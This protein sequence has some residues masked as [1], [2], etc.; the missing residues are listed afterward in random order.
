MNMFPAMEYAALR[1]QPIQKLRDV[2]S[3]VE[4]LLSYSELL[5]AELHIKLDTFHADITTALE[6]RQDPDG[7]S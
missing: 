1:Q 4:E 3:T 2:Y 7:T 6:D 5:P